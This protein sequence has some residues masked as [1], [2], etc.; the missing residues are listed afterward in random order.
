MNIVPF[1]RPKTG[2]GSTVFLQNCD[3]DDHTIYNIPEP[4]RDKDGCMNPGAMPHRG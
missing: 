3:P 4:G 2:H 1:H